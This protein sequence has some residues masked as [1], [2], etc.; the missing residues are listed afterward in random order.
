MVRALATVTSRQRRSLR[1]AAA[2]RGRAA[3]LALALVPLWPVA[4]AYSRA[5]EV[6]MAATLALSALPAAVLVVSAAVA[7]VLAVVLVE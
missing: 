4:E 3:V 7:V 1:L 5:R 2:V 6:A